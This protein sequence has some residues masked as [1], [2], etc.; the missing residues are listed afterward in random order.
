VAYQAHPLQK[1]AHADALPAKRSPTAYA[2]HYACPAM[3]L[4]GASTPGASGSGFLTG[5]R[6]E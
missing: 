1:R 5:I 4:F 6:M 2:R 3:H